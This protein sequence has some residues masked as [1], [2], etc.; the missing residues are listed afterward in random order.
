MCT[1]AVKD[2]FLAVP[3]PTRALLVEKVLHVAKALNLVIS[4]GRGGGDGLEYYGDMTHVVPDCKLP[5]GFYQEEWTS[6]ED[7]IRHRLYCLAAQLL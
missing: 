2:A 5:P 7:T 4:D 1:E 3:F 6:P